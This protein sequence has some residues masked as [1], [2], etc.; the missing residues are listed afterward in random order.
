MARRGRTTTSSAS[1]SSRAARGAA[2]ALIALLIAAAAGPAAAEPTPA[3]AAEAQRLFDEGRRLLSAGSAEACPK[4][5]RSQQLDPGIGTLLNLAACYES[6]GRVASAW[7]AFTDAEQQARAAGERKREKVAHDRAQALEPRLP[8]LLIRVAGATDSASHAGPD[9][10]TV[11]RDGQ[12]IGAVEIDQPIPVDPGPHLVEAEAPGHA[13]F[14][15]SI[16]AEEGKLATVDIQL[17]AA[18]EA[19]VG[20]G[21]GDRRPGRHIGPGDD[22]GSSPGRGRR[23]LGLVSGGVGLAALGGSLL[24]ALDADSSYDDAFEKGLCDR[25]THACSEAGYAQT[26]D[27]RSQGNLATIVGGVGLAAVAA[28]VY[29]WLSAPDGDEP[30]ATS[31]RLIPTVTPGQVGFTLLRAF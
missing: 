11:R 25:D 19:E 13:S 7:R 26:S 20:A 2:A 1:G 10:L 16:V 27:A 30:S 6:V 4:F 22:G 12:A 24:L 23:I 15:T 18:D 5:E 29:L 9:G 21:G 8:R 31:A 3:E 17:A 14:R 28:G